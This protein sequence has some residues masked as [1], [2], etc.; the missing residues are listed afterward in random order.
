MQIPNLRYNL[1][2]ARWKKQ[3]SLWGTWGPAA[4]DIPRLVHADPREHTMEGYPIS[5]KPLLR[6]NPLVKLK[7]TAL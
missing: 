6:K 3:D 7:L 5:F 4:K 2:F 1:I